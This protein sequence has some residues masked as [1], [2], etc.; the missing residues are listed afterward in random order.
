MKR[1]YQSPSRIYFLFAQYVIGYIA[2]IAVFA[3]YI[4]VIFFGKTVS[5]APENLL[6]YAMIFVLWAEVAKLKAGE[7]P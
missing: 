1:Q 7:K 4:A 2:A 5:T 6:Q 3:T